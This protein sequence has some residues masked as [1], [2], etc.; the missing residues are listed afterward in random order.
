M[1]RV[2]YIEDNRMYNKEL[3]ITDK[4]ILGNFCICY[5]FPTDRWNLRKVK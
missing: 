2:A 1:F 4:L 3:E 5:A